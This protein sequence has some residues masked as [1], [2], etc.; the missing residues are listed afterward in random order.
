MLLA[1]CIHRAHKAR[2]RPRGFLPLTAFFAGTPPKTQL[3]TTEMSQT[4][5][6]PLISSAVAAGA[7][8]SPNPI[9]TRYSR[10]FS[11]SATSSLSP[12]LPAA[13]LQHSHSIGSSSGQS[14]AHTRATADLDILQT[15]PGSPHVGGLLPIIS[16]AA[17]G[18]ASASRAIEPESSPLHR[19]M[20][21]HQKALETDTKGHEEEGTIEIDK[22]EGMNDPPPG[23][24]D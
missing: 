10:S 20:T 2:K 13:S 4:H 1:K 18:S 14:T 9:F 11:T 7:T 15:P 23:Y 19:A 22:I 8:S 21:L 24:N 3:P 6:S 5:S 12:L 16:A 17:S